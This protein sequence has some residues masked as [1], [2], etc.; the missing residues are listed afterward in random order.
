MSERIVITEPG[1]YAD[2]DEDVYHADP[3]PEGS[4]SSTGARAILPPGTPAKFNWQRRRTVHKKEWDL[5]SAA[6][7]LVLGT[8]PEIV[9]IDADSYRTKDAQASRDAAYGDGKIPLLPSEYEDV[10]SMVI[11]IRRHPV[12]GPL[13][14]KGTGMAEQSLFWVDELTGVWCRGRL[15]WMKP[16]ATGGRLIVAD[17]K[18]AAAADE[19]SISK[20]VARFGYH[21]QADWYQSGVR[22]LGIHADPAYVLVFVEKTPPHQVHVVQ[23]DPY[24]LQLARL[25]NRR[26]LEIY[27]ACTDSGEW[28]GYPTDITTV[29]LPAW[30]ERTESEEYLPS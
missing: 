4:L 13:F 17:L 25:K 27:K 7:N 11:A 8:G 28:P 3:V 24:T 1:I 15:D 21:Q 20:T 18:T 29:S 30:A 14:A 9:I 10:L 2:L 22:A 5:G 12:A 26:A 16:A 23:L 19:E 6:H